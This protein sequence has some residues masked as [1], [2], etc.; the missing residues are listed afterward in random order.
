M[1]ECPFQILRTGLCQYSDIQS[2]FH[3]GFKRILAKVKEYIQAD[4]LLKAVRYQMII[5][6]ES[7]KKGECSSLLLKER[8]Y[9]DFY[10]LLSFVREA[11]HI[12]YDIV[13][14][15]VY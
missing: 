11:S 15:G 3:K 5:G 1:E 2:Y 4:L 7:Q 8:L 10:E 9:E 13:V 14:Q 6:G 12:K